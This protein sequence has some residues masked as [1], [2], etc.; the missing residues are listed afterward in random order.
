[1]VERE[2]R[3]TAESDEAD[4]GAPRT[5]KKASGKNSRVNARRRQ[6]LNAEH[7]DAL[8]DRPDDERDAD[9]VMDEMSDEERLALFFSSSTEAALPSL[10]EIPGFHVCWLT[11]ASRNDTIQKRLRLGYTLIKAKELGSDFASMGVQNGDYAGYVMVNEMIAAKLPK[12]LYQMFM[13]KA[14]H[15]D[16]LREEEG[17]KSRVRQHDAALDEYGSG[18]VDDSAVADLGVR[19]PAPDFAR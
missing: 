5:T 10:P 16:P 3:L 9:A 6:M 4:T 17:I 8:N 14:H 2:Q 15:D 18:I 12:R 11:T 19:R 1:M 7:D 13:R